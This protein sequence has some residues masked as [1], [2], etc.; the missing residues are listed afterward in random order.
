MSLEPD[1]D[2]NVAAVG[3]TADPDAQMPRYAR[4]DSK[5]EEERMQQ[6]ESQLARLQEENERLKSS[7]L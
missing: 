3:E 6:L 7:T 2:Q 5:A 4:E 1:I